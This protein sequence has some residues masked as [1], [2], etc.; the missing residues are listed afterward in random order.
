MRSEEMEQRAADCSREETGNPGIPYGSKR[1][2]WQEQMPGW[3]CVSSPIDDPLDIYP[4]VPPAG[5]ESSF[6]WIDYAKLEIPPE[7]LSEAKRQAALAELNTFIEAQHA[8]FTGF[9][10]NEDLHYREGGADSPP[11][12]LAWLFDIH[13]NNIGEPFQTGI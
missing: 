4:Q 13:S 5:L 7:G 1:L 2:P 11:T 12:D 9:Q 6:P 10:L 3:A 8:S